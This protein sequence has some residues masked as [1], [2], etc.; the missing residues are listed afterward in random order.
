MIFALNN[1]QEMQGR[2]VRETPDLRD[3]AEDRDNE[4]TPQSK[5]KAAAHRPSPNTVL[6]PFST[7]SSASSRRPGE[8]SLDSSF[9]TECNIDGHSPPHTPLAASGDSGHLKESVRD[10]VQVDA[11]QNSS[12]RDDVDGD[13]FDFAASHSWLKRRPT[14][15]DDATLESSS[16]IVPADRRAL[17][18][19]LA[20]SADGS[21]IHRRL[22]ELRLALRTAEEALD[23][24]RLRLEESE[25]GRHDAESEAMALR[26]RVW[27]LEGGEALSG[28]RLHDGT[29]DLLRGELLNEATEE[30]EEAARA[31]AEAEVRAQEAIRA[32]KH[33]EDAAAAVASA[34]K[35]EVESLSLEAAQARLRA[36]AE[37]RDATV[38][39]EACKQAELAKI[40]AEAEAAKWREFGEHESVS[41]AKAEEAAKRAKAEAQEAMAARIA[42]EK[43]AAEAAEHNNFLQQRVREL[44]DDQGADRSAHYG[45]ELR[46][47]R[48]KLAADAAKAADELA[49]ERAVRQTLEVELIEARR[50]GS[51]GGPGNHTADSS[52]PA[53]VAAEAKTTSSEAVAALETQLIGERKETATLKRQV[54]AATVAAA[55]SSSQQQQDLRESQDSWA[56]ALGLMEFDVECDASIAGDEDQ[57]KIP[58]VG[59][60][61]ANAE[62]INVVS[63]P[64]FESAASSTADKEKKGKK[65]GIT[66]SSAKGGQ[67]RDAL[68]EAARREIL[69]LQDVNQRLMASRLTTQQHV[70]AASVAS[71][72]AVDAALARNNEAWAVKLAQAE[73]TA[74]EAG[75]AAER[76][77]RRVAVLEA[78]CAD[79]HSELSQIRGKEASIADREAA[80]AAAVEAAKAK[81]AARAEEEKEA[82]EAR[83]AEQREAMKAEAERE[84]E[85]LEAE[86]EW[87]EKLTE[88]RQTAAEAEARLAA[89]QSFAAEAKEDAA[90]AVNRIV[91]LKKEC[92]DAHR[93]IEMMRERELAAELAAEANA[94]LAALEAGA[95]AKAEA[96]EALEQAR[97]E[98]AAARD[99]LNNL[100]ESIRITNER[101]APA[102]VASA[103]ATAD[104]MGSESVVSPSPM[105]TP[106][107]HTLDEPTKSTESPMRPVAVTVVQMTD[108]NL[109]NDAE[110]DSDDDEGEVDEETAVAVVSEQQMEAREIS[111]SI[112]SSEDEDEDSECEES[113]LERAMRRDREAEDAARMIRKSCEGST[114]PRRRISSGG[115]SPESMPETPLQ[116]RFA[117]AAAEAAAEAEAAKSQSHISQPSAL[118]SER[119]ID[120]D[121]SEPESATSGIREEGQ[122]IW[123]PRGPPHE[124]SDPYVGG[125]TSAKQRRSARKDKVTEPLKEGSKLGTE[126]AKV[127]DDG[128]ACAEMSST[129]YPQGGAV[130]VT[131]AAAAKVMAAAVPVVTAVAAARNK[132]G[133]AASV[134]RRLDV[135]HEALHSLTSRS[136]GHLSDT[137]LGH[138]SARI[139]SGRLSR[140]ATHPGHSSAVDSI[141]EGSMAAVLSGANMSSS[142]DDD[143][144]RMSSDDES[145]DPSATLSTKGRHKRRD[146]SGA[147]AGDSVEAVDESARHEEQ[148]QAISQPS[149]PSQSS[150]RR[151]HEGHNMTLPRVS[152]SPMRNDALPTQT[153]DSAIGDRRE[154]E[155][156]SPGSASDISVSQS[157]S[158][159]SEAFT[160]VAVSAQAAATAASN[161]LR[162]SQSRLKSPY[163]TPKVSPAKFAAASPARMSSMSTPVSTPGSTPVS[164]RARELSQQ[165]G[166]AV[167]ASGSLRSSS[168]SFVERSLREGEAAVQ[169]MRASRA[170]LASARSSRAAPSSSALSTPKRR[171]SSATAATVATAGRA[172][173]TKT[174]SRS[175][176]PTKKSG[177]LGTGKT[178]TDTWGRPTGT[179][180]R[181]SPVTG[182]RPTNI[183][184]SQTTTT[185]RTRNVPPQAFNHRYA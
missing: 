88:A 38:A 95:E 13:S 24:T 63:N 122:W 130:A 171:L 154:K 50:S 137:N 40:G 49:A 41:C 174:S 167:R 84:R 180:G 127:A 183:G 112:H 111:S 100:R 121:V 77:A 163:S 89:A 126:A 3:S 169:A 42:A 70:T 92:A 76:A 37:G 108:G 83:A 118:V 102:A 14:V 138:F 82:T 7:L 157:S 6:S 153:E 28:A 48:E 87:E 109:D 114:P 59:P 21:M 73:R 162:R 72:A 51:T 96:A 8:S 2:G 149:P 43:A 18:T 90:R 33:A 85:A 15:A 139:D 45:S 124:G 134:A 4:R 23:K 22:S 165:S 10:D 12:A 143:F 132:G 26:A 159:A 156:A 182:S 181:P 178:V 66:D 150:S 168:Q 123:Q 67:L 35:G 142:D 62:E 135:D 56:D 11:S 115:T 74:A 93:E 58:A 104:V 20:P 60:I 166:I 179:W 128:M 119:D 64:T 52:L 110:V 133:K 55:D 9:E 175:P 68:L 1:L 27:T 46:R 47:L 29:L 145:T 131:V 107:A 101:A 173:A 34:A 17:L 170:S 32:L 75:E 57:P 172:V 125:K 44:E 141:G 136:Y 161:A 53:A 113:P 148:E 160:A 16:F 103:T 155:K 106:R 177:S 54:E 91:E 164:A 5:T 158:R 98:A 176:L 97:T 120:M 147:T 144:C 146:S 105:I 71:T 25:A 65:A 151:E 30:L 129:D 140:V 185:S 81:E 99:E 152:H 184:G 117:A 79:A 61:E 80:V 39:R 36:Q 69:H 19:P 86:K 78:E 94:A 116:A 31:T